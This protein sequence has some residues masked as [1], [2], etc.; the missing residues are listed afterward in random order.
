MEKMNNIEMAKELSSI[1]QLDV[2]AAHAFGEAIEKTEILSLRDQFRK[3][4]DAH[5]LHVQ[6]LSK[7][8]RAL[9]VIPPEYTQDFKGVLMEGWAAIRGSM[10]VEGTLKAMKTNMEYTAKKYREA[11]ALPFTPN[12]QDLVERNYRVV[13]GH[14][15]FLEKALANRVW[16]QG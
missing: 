16:E 10:G 12:I 14:L 3:F 9:D 8:I 11:T 15:E 2:N 1:V 7:V 5:N 4:R 6:A 13:Q